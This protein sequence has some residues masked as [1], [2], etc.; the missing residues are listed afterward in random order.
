[1]KIQVVTVDKPGLLADITSALKSADVNVTK[2]SVETQDNQ[3][4]RPFHH[5]GGGPAAPGQGLRGLEAA[6]GSDFG[7]EEDGVGQGVRGK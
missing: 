7:P 1:M 6:E 5:P 2:A 3:G 4:H